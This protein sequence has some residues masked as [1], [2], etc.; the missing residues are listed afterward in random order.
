MYEINKLLHGQG[1][2]TEFSHSLFVSEI[3]LARCARSFDFWYITNSCENPVRAP[4]PWSNLYLFDNWNLSNEFTRATN[5]RQ[6]RR[7]IRRTIVTKCRLTQIRI[8]LVRLMKSSTFG[9]DLISHSQLMWLKLKNGESLTCL[10]VEP[11]FKGHH[12]EYPPSLED[13]IWKIALNYILRRE[14]DRSL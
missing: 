10:W 6:H 1:A 12:R 14:R 9:L 8:W 11:P 5:R 13:W 3:S 4:C 7:L 2:C